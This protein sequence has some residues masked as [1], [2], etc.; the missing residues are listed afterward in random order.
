MLARRATRV[1]K[2]GSSAASDVYKIKD[3]IDDN[4]VRD[5]WSENTK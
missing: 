2:S 4:E 1:K 3:Y 5:E